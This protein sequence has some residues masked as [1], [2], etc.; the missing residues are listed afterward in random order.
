MEGEFVEWD[1]K[2]HWE[3][4]KKEAQKTKRKKKYSKVHRNAYNRYRQ[5][6]YSEKSSA[7]FSLV[8]VSL[9]LWLFSSLLLPFPRTFT[10]SSLSLR[11]FHFRN[12]KR[13]GKIICATST[14][15]MSPSTSLRWVCDEKSFDS[16]VRAGTFLV[17]VNF[18]SPLPLLR[19]GKCFNQFCMKLSSLDGVT[20]TTPTTSPS[21][22]PSKESYIHGDKL[23]HTK[24]LKSMVIAR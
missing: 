22:R 8:S 15:S 13:T 7:P 5:I 18:S 19:A 9:C 24:R 10:G 11:F 12:W 2:S 21:S 16:F 17:T 1:K 23:S 14:S 6:N 3:R 20:T 4:G